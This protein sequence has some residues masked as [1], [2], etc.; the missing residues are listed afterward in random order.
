MYPTAV[1]SSTIFSG[2]SAGCVMHCQARTKKEK[3]SG[4]WVRSLVSTEALGGKMKL[5]PYSSVEKRLKYTSRRRPV[6]VQP[7]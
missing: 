4:A 3:P 1:T 2:L 7:T 5:C 6:E